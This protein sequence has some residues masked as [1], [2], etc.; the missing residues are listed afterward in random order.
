M[1]E[2]WR[3]PWFLAMLKRWAGRIGRRTRRDGGTIPFRRYLELLATAEGSRYMAGA[4]ELRVFREN[5]WSPEFSTLRAD[6]ELPDYVPQSRLEASALWVSAKGVRS[7][8]HYDGNLQ[9]NLNAQVM[10]SKQVQLFSPDQM[11][12]MYPYMYTS[13]RP[14]TFSQVNVED[15]DQREFPRFAQVEGFEGTLGTGELLFIPAYWYHTFK[16]LGDF[17]VNVNFWWRAEF[18]RLSPVSARDYLGGVALR[19]LSA[20]RVPPVWLMGWFR[21]FEK[22]ITGPPGGVRR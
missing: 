4:E 13:A 16:H 11:T 3:R 22:Q 9:H 6:Y 2:A 1:R 15:V 18:V 7:H 20:S 21:K 12:N 8:L 19:V 17:N 14:Y 10:G 5:E